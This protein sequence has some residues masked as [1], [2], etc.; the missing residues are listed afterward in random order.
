MFCKHRGLAVREYVAG[1]KGEA[2][3]DQI[4]LE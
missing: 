3:T 4:Q 2:E 1:L